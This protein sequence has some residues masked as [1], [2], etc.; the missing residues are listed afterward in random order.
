MAKKKHKVGFKGRLAQ[1]YVVLALFIDNFVMFFPFWITRP[2][3]KDT[4]KS[5]KNRDALSTRFAIYVVF[6][7]MYGAFRLIKYC[8]G[9]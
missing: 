4:L 9:W 2:G 8:L 7:L 3:Y 1:A 5:K 6:G